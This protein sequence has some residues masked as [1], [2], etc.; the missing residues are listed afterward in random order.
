MKQAP[1]SHSADT[2]FGAFIHLSDKDLWAT[3]LKGD[4]PAFAFIYEKFADALFS[5]GMKIKP[6]RS[7]V[8]DCI[9]DLF[10]DLWNYRAS[11][12]ATDNIKFYLFRSLRRK[13][14]YCI[15][16][17][18]TLYDEYPLHEHEE[19]DVSLPF[20]HSLILKQNEEEKKRK[21][22]KVLSRLPARQQ[23]V[24][25]LIFF[26]QFSYEEVSEIMAI[27]VR[28]VYTLA[29]KALSALRKNLPDLLLLTIILNL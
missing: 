3:F 18:R 10:V 5:Y 7:L 4:K 2:P 11:L 6:N 17:E 9:H 15:D 28:S 26:D 20:E 1:H 23:E 8:K 27:N 19:L 29:W 16:R 24:L 13:I 12:S 14:R 25:K 22:A 21:I